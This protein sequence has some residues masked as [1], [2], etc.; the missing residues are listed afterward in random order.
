MHKFI[1]TIRSN[2]K[3]LQKFNSNRGKLDG[4]TKISIWEFR[5][6]SSSEWN[7]VF[8]FFPNWFIIEL[9]FVYFFMLLLF[10]QHSLVCTYSRILLFL[11]GENGRETER[12][13]RLRSVCIDS[14]TIFFN[15]IEEMTHKCQN[16]E[17]DWT[18]LVQPSMSN[19]HS[20]SVITSSRKWKRRKYSESKDITQN[21]SMPNTQKMTIRDLM[22]VRIISGIAA[23]IWIASLAAFLICFIVY[24]FYGTLTAL[25]LLSMAAL[26]KQAQ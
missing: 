25:G 23:K 8:S 7:K 4:T 22:I 9:F 1:I 14:G 16:F 20:V 11:S 5:R 17:L 24:F 21:K 13:L 18:I 19:I 12:L 6:E 3:A 10:C 15:P 2:K 26:C